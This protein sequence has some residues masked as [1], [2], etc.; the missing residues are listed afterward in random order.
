MPTSAMYTIRVAGHLD[1]VWSE[2]FAG[3][4]VVPEPDGETVISGTVR[5]QAELH[6]LLNTLFRLNLVLID[7]RRVDRS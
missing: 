7:V 2:S 4:A 3:F 5:D 6:G 1:P